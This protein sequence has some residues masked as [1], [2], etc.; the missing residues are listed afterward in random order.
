MSLRLQLLQVARLA[1][2]LLADST[3]LVREFFA[4]Q[5]NANGAACDRGGKPDLYYTIF[6]LAGAQAL[7]VTIPAAA[8]AEWLKSF[9]EGASLDFVHL[10]ALA[11]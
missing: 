6:A 5:F 2:R 7:D 10:G 8:T 1:P 11:R 9:D 4:K 3:A